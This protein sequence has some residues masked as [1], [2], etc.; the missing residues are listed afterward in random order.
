V[1]VYGH[2]FDGELNFGELDNEETITTIEK[3]EQN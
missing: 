2:G 1:Q 3:N